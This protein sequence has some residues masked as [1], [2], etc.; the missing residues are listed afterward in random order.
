LLAQDGVIGG[1]Q[2]IAVQQTLGKALTIVGRAHLVPEPLE[3][4]ALG[5][6]HFGSHGVQERQGGEQVLPRTA[7]TPGVL[8]ARAPRSAR[9]LVV[10]QRVQPSE[11][12]THHGELLRA[13]GEPAAFNEP[14]DENRATAEVRYRVIDRQALRGIVLSL[15]EPQDRGVALHAYPR[16]G[17]GKGPCDPRVAVPAVD[18]EDV[19]LVHA[20]LGC[21]DSVDP[22]AIPQM[23]EQV[24][25]C[26]LVVDS[27][28][29]TLQIGQGFGV[30]LTGVL[31]VV[32][33]DLLETAVLR[34]GQASS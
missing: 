8:T 30:A 15:Q 27:P 32:A 23:G 1:V 5:G 21:R 28:A 9:G 12:V 19:G 29:Q 18:A 34:H 24:F 25:T 4:F 7:F 20:E 13:V 22:V 17:G 31:R 10:G 11:Q 14:S 2:E 16:A 33:N 3:S 6:R 26:G